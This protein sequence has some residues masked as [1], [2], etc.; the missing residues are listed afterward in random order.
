MKIFF[1]IM[2]NT[3]VIIFCILSGFLSRK[4]EVVTFSGH[5]GDLHDLD[6]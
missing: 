3:G 2:V 4:Q 5:T 1:L 6:V